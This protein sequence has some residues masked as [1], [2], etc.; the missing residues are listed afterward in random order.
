VVEEDFTFD[1]ALR[2]RLWRAE[3]NVAKGIMA[4]VPKEDVARE[5]IYLMQF[6]ALRWREL[7]RRAKKVI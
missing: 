2:S 3:A 4:H 6:R 7:E 5:M 1:D